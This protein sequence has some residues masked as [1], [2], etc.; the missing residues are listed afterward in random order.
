MMQSSADVGAA[1]AAASLTCALLFAS[2]DLP[3]RAG[4]PLSPAAHAESDGPLPAHTGGFAEP[5]CH[6][7]HFQADVNA[8]DGSI[9]LDGIPSEYVGGTIYD[10][11]I[12]LAQEGL[13]AGGFQLSSRFDDGA[14][15]GVFA[16]SPSDVGR[17]TVTTE[18]GVQYIHHVYPGTRRTAPDT[19]RWLIRWTAPEASGLIVFHIAANA[20]DDDG[21]PLGDMIYA[22]SLRTVPGK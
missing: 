3:A 20:A 13:A 9:T 19:A 6:A 15:A 21:S 16:S 2:T 4:A 5:T 12:T 14:Q 11:T 8:G 18:G 7:C 17:V 22:T 10:I 1:V